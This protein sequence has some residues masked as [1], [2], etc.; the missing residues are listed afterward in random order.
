MTAATLPS[1]HGVA[2]MR[3]M[4]FT[5]AI[6]LYINDLA[7]RSKSKATRDTYFRMLSNMADGAGRHREVSSLELV[8]YERFLHRWVNAKPSTLASGVS[9]VRGFSKFC[10]KRGIA[11]TDVAAPLQRPRRLPA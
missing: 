6:D 4:R 7:L 9:C 2:N 1:A 3:A 10:K 8:D 5:E 11:D